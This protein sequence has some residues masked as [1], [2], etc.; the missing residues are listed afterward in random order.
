MTE[1]DQPGDDDSSLETD[2]TVQ[3][4]FDWDSVEPSTAVVETIS[5]AANADPSTIK[6]LYGSIDPDAL[7]ELVRSNRT[8]SADTATT[9]SFTFAGHE[10]T[11][12]SNGTVVVRPI[13]DD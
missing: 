4:E 8:G 9:V 7:D 6:P 2:G 10:V 5:V 1:S 11:L 13:G 3:A 12:Y